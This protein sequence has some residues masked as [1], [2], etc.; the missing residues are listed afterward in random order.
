[1]LAAVLV[2][3][4]S[5]PPRSDRKVSV[6]VILAKRQR[7]SVVAAGPNPGRTEITD[8]RGSGVFAGKS[9]FGRQA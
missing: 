4:S 1:M 8:G 3:G 6:F 2:G 9:Q 5:L 7:G